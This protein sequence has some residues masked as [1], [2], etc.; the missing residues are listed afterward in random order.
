MD[1]SST[2]LKMQTHV[3]LVCLFV[4]LFESAFLITRANW[5]EFEGGEKK[6]GKNNGILRTVI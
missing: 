3:L 6:M 4:N 1:I 2:Q 5:V